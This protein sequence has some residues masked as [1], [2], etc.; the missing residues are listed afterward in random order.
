MY[1]LP[2][3]IASFVVTISVVLVSD[4][5]ALAWVLG[6]KAVLSKQKLT[7]LHNLIKLGLLVSVTT[8]ALMFWPAREYLVTSPAFWVKMFFVFVLIINGYLIGRHL[9][10]PPT[11]SFASLEKDEKRPLIISA[12]V[13]TISWITVFVSALFIWG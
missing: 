6:K 12:L 2:I 3:H 11:K 13:S 7:G 9:N 8:G 1:V 5:Y 4:I 10:I